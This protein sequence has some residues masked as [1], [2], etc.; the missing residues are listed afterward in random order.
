MEVAKLCDGKAQLYLARE[1]LADA[2]PA[3]IVAEGRRW[4]DAAIAQDS[5]EGML[6]LGALMR[7]GR[8]GVPVDH[9]PSLAGIHRAAENRY[10]PALNEL[11][12][13]FHAGATGRYRKS[14][15]WGKSEN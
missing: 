15:V 1:M 10:T 5:V 11:G 14:G 9:A 7:H 2:R 8:D 3:A 13:H 4:L 12:Q 6:L